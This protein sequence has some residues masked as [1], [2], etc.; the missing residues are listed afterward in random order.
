MA[1]FDPGKLTR[2]MIQTNK[3]GA[4]AG[5]VLGFMAMRKFVPSSPWYIKTIGVIGGIVG[6][7]YAQNAIRTKGQF[8]KT[9]KFAKE[10]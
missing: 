10:K 2:A 7:A 5:A 8:L 4:A 6:G 3:L 1:V 9:A